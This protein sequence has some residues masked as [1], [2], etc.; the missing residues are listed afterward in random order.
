[1]KNHCVTP[2]A[3]DIIQGKKSDDHRLSE[4]AKYKKRKGLYERSKGM[5]ENCCVCNGA[6]ACDGVIGL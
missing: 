1:M 5:Y 2:C 6:V 3:Y 4:G